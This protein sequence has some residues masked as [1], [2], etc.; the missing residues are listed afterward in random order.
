MYISGLINDVKVNRKFQFLLIALSVFS[1]VEKPSIVIDI[2]YGDQQQFGKIGIAQKWIN[3]LGNVSSNSGIKNCSYSLND[4]DTVMMTLGS[5]LHRLAAP[6]D[7][8]IDLNIDECREGVNKLQISALDSAGNFKVN[9]ITFSVYKNNQWP[10]PYS[11]RWD[12]VENIQEVAQVVDG[13]WIINE[14]GL[15]NLDV[16]YDRVVAIGDSS[17]HNYEVSTTVTFHGFTPPAPGPP[18][19]SVTHAAI[20]SRF[21]GHSEDGL[22]PFRQWYPL[23]AT[24][25]FR[26][27]A[28]LDSCRWRIF[29][30]PKPASK[31]F[32]VEQEVSE[33]RSI[34][35]ER[36]YGMKHRVETVGENTTKYSVKLWSI[37]QEEPADWDFYGI[38]EE[39][40]LP[41][42]CALLIAHHTSVTFGDVYVIPIRE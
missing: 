24:S 1:C 30:G 22:Q 20:S 29:D 14:N 27:T 5:D 38:E 41:S 6:G 31:K 18:T 42:G 40:N 15:H 21:P 19:Y 23:G 11:I 4:A 9:E 35:L 28:G 26:L 34:E 13:H 12:E 25:E 16:Y 3:I 2:W 10:L 32:Y 33:Y 39:E 37:D 8:N 7:F 36:T 17:W